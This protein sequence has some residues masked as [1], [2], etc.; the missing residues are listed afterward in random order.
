MNTYTDHTVTMIA[1]DLSM[2]DIC[3]I[4]KIS[5]YKQEKKKWQTIYLDAID[6]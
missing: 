6:A 2:S 4:E 5:L 3:Q 1:Y